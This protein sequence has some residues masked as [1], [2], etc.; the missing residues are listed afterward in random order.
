VRQEGGFLSRSLMRRRQEGGQWLKLLTHCQVLK[1]A[2]QSRLR[3]LKLPAETT[4]PLLL[5]RSHPQF[6]PRALSAR[7]E[8]L[9]LLE[10]LIVAPAAAPLLYRP[11]SKHAIGVDNLA[12]LTGFAY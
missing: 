8:W 2:F 1:H 6:P 9:P 4:D 12:K 5:K 11:G 3:F 7:F 10:D